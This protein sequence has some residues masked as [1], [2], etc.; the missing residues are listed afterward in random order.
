MAADVTTIS[1]VSCIP[2]DVATDG[3]VKEKGLYVMVGFSICFLVDVVGWWFIPKCTRCPPFYDEF[4]ANN[5]SVRET[6][7]K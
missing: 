4:G 7:V 5:D 1:L 6:K 3:S 2:L